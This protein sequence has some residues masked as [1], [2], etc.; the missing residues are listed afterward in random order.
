[1][2]RLM[3]VMTDTATMS[4]F[5]LVEHYESVLHTLADAAQALAD[6]PAAQD[7]EVS[8]LG[9]P[10]KM[11]TRELQEHLTMQMAFFSRMVEMVRDR[12]TRNEGKVA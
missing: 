11:N 1:M 4:D 5:E 8:I 6:K 12:I 10:C 7:V 9:M 2:M 3:D